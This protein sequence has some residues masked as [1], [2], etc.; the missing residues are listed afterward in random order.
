MHHLQYPVTYDHDATT[1]VSFMLVFA[2][3]TNKRPIFMMILW[4][5]ETRHT[6][7]VRVAVL[8]RMAKRAGPALCAAV[9]AFVSV[10]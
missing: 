4:G 9:M 1:V 10:A 7:R 6:R 5:Y 3:P 8:L 2:D